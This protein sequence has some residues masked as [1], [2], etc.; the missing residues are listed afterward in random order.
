MMLAG[1]ELIGRGA[2]GVNA[3]QGGDQAC[4]VEASRR[5]EAIRQINNCYTKHVQEQKEADKG[6]GV[7]AKGSAGGSASSASVALSSVSGSQR[8]D[9]GQQHQHQHQQE[10]HKQQ[11]QQQHHHHHHH[12]REQQQQ[13]HEQHGQQQEQAKEQELEQGGTSAQS[14]GEGAQGVQQPAPDCLSNLTGAYNLL[15]TMTRSEAR[16][17]AQY[18]RECV[19]LAVEDIA[20]ANQ[21]DR[22][23]A[24]RRVLKHIVNELF[25]PPKQ[26]KTVRDGGDES[27]YAYEAQICIRLESEL[28]R[29]EEGTPKDPTPDS[30]LK[31]VHAL[32]SKVFLQKGNAKRE[33]FLEVEIWPF[34]ATLL[35]KTVV[36]IS[37]T[38][39]LALPPALAE[40]HDDE[41]AAA[42]AAAGGFTTSAKTT[43]LLLGEGAG[44]T[45]SVSYTP[46]QQAASSLQQTPVYDLDDANKPSSKTSPFSAQGNSPAVNSQGS[47]II[48]GLQVTCLNEHTLTH[49]LGA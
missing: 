15:L 18:L 27:V 22:A 35:P 11:Q 30:R 10:Q 47:S 45:A 33:E 41:I 9:K 40:K 25:L 46:Q 13:R 34:Y 31:P 24:R 26:V 17:P 38:F 14:C 48:A 4:G 49:L 37:K 19:A 12:H 36:L 23:L 21:G 42:A 28:L 43:S 16:R 44:G 6:H 32:L 5:L 29:G 1:N 3:K 7:F 39:D 20:S 2:A 8:H